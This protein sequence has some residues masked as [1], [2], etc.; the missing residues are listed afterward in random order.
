MLP[1]IYLYIYIYLPTYT[2]ISNWQCDR[3]RKG[4]QLNR[5]QSVNMKKIMDMVFTYIL[6]CLNNTFSQIFSFLPATLSLH[7][8]F[9]LTSH[10]LSRS[11]LSNWPPGL[12]P[13]AETQNLNRN[14]G[15]C[16]RWFLQN[17]APQFDHQRL[18][19]HPWEQACC[20]ITRYVHNCNT[21]WQFLSIKAQAIRKDLCWQNGATISK[22]R[23]FFTHSKRKIQC[24]PFE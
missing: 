20:Q 3:S 24:E 1:N 15:T 13:C 12:R 19:V 22:Q 21:R 10:T 23:L 14:E 2:C 11:P 18:I 16:I 4:N 8:Q 17:W 9:H 5:K 7:S 6:F